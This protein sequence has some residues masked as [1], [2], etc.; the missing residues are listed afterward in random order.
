MELQQHVSADLNFTPY[1]HVVECFRSVLW[2]FVVSCVLNEPFLASCPRLNRY[3]EAMF[4]NH[5]VARLNSSRFLSLYF[6]ILRHKFTMA[7]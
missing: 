3:L 4:H 5:E 1:K 6:V 7:E 2:M